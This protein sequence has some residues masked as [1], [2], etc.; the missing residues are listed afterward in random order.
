M[1]IYL[2]SFNAIL[3]RDLRN[4]ILNPV[5]IM[6][7]SVFPL[8]LIAVL[9]YMTGTVYGG[10]EVTS[11]D[12]YGVTI[13]IFTALNVSMIAA[14][15]FMEKSLKTS[16]LRIL[17]SPIPTF[18][19]YVSKMAATFLFA[20]ASSFLLIGLTRLLFGI[21]FGGGN[22][23]CVALILTGFNLFSSALG[24]LL[25][26]LLKSEELSNKILSMIN[27]ALALVGGLFFQLD[28]LGSAIETISYLS[29]VKWVA[30]AVF[31]II[32]D[33]DFGLFLPSVGFC[34]LGT[35]L[36]LWGCKLTFRAEDYV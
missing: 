29:P 8:L 22:W 34:I 12:Y 20:S 35:L 36:L 7:N 21:N 16:N 4:L 13:L 18:Y 11:Y 10:G 17:Y 26:C 31:R 23:I 24:V 30:E 27:N 33:H 15:S 5:M 28:G 25:C 1:R 6:S 19:I 32:Y 2:R 14:N 9:G 3:T